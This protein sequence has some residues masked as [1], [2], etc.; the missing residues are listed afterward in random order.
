M[1]FTFLCKNFKS[2]FTHIFCNFLLPYKQNPQTF[3]CLE[4]V[5][6][7]CPSVLWVCYECALSWSLLWPCVQCAWGW[8]KIWWD[9]CI[10]GWVKYRA[11]YCANNCN[12]I[13]LCVPACQLL[14]NWS[15]DYVA[16]ESEAV[17][18]CQPYDSLSAKWHMTYDTVSAIWWQIP[19]RGQ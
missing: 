6:G 7:C 15:D 5:L 10:S 18:L 19:Q 9:G 8:V 13:H 14:A 11:P 17:S 3:C 12:A 4:S 16:N 2:R 1:K